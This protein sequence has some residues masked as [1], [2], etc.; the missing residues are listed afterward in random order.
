MALGSKKSCQEDFQEIGGQEDK[1]R[2]GICL[3][4]MERWY[5][6]VAAFH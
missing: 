3:R 6:P 4:V 5:G 2:A 1:A